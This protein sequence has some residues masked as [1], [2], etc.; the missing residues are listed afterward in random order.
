M[1]GVDVSHGDTIESSVVLSELSEDNFTAYLKLAM[2]VNNFA[3][4]QS[5]SVLILSLNNLVPNWNADSKVCKAWRA[6]LVQHQ[7]EPLAQLLAMSSSKE[8]TDKM[9]KMKKEKR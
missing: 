9:K 1:F 8:S 3:D 7:R 5:Q 2:K 6:S 4:Y